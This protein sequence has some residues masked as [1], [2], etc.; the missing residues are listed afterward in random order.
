[1]LLTPKFE[2]NTSFKLLAL[3]VFIN[4]SQKFQNV[5]FGLESKK[6]LIMLFF[7]LSG[8]QKLVMQ[9]IIGKQCSCALVHEENIYHVL[10]KV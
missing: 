6:E 4:Y 5:L 7:L 1:M 10:N 8:T 3:N 2:H 9:S